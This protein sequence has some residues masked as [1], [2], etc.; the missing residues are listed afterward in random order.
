V[1]FFDIGQE[2]VSSIYAMFDTDEPARGLGIFTLLAELE[3]AK[4][5][6]KKYLYTGYVHD[7]PSFYDYKKHFA[8]LEYY[9]W[10]G[11]WLPYIPKRELQ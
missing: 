6:G 4:H 9:D 11:R 5:H 8:A 7:E 10:Q 2:A 1:S 3:F